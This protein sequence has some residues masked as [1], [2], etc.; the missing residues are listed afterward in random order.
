MEIVYVYTK[1]RSEFG[2]QPIFTDR[3]PELCVNIRPDPSL[4]DDY[5]RRDPV[6]TAVQYT[7]DMSEHEVN[8]GQHLSFF[9]HELLTFRSTQKDLRQTVEE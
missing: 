4:K 5:I 8:T 6:D 3:P 9:L 7:P 2:R 1:K